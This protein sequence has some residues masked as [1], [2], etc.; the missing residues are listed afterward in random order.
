MTTRPPAI[1][2]LED[3]TVFRGTSFGARVLN[4]GEVIAR[5]A[6]DSVRADPRVLEAYFGH[7]RRAAGGS[8]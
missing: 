8:S 4:E 7:T 2:A 6:F 1:L 3:G 5:G